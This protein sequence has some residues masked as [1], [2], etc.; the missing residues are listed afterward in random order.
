MPRL[1]LGRPL[2]L[3]RRASRPPRFSRYRGNL[4]VDVVIIGGGVT[5]A[6]A[7]YAFAD[8]GLAVALLEAGRI[9][10]GSTAASTALLMQEPDEDFRELVRRYGRRAARRMWQAIGSAT[11]DLVT[12]I[13][14]LRISCELRQ[15]SSIYYTHTDEVGDLREEFEARRAAGLK[16]R[17]L[18]ARA[19]KRR[20]GIAAA[21]AILTPG[22]AQ[23]DPYKACLG[24]AQRALARGARIFEYSAARRVKV[25]RG[26][27]AVTTKAGSLRAKCVVIATG[28]ATAEFKPLAG[29]FRMMNTYVIATPPLSRTIRRRL[30]PP[31]LML[32][33]TARPYHY[34]RWT[35]DGRLLFGGADTPHRPSRSRKKALDNGAAELRR[36]L[37]RLYPVLASHEADYVW[38]GLFAQTP[39]GLPYIGSHHR[40]PRHLFALG[41]GGNGMSVAYLA[42]RMLLRQYQG[43][44]TIDDGLFAFGRSRRRPAQARV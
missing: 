1:R 2:W 24:L 28:Y 44:S 22:N 8:A 10:R 32:W 18:S 23:L 13:K 33:D 11:T 26:G 25:L 39:D 3:D 27:V 40:Y 38:E 31:D 29:R 36:D 20:T 4:S 42:A 34:L 41:Y 12:L 17:W 37:R 15:G 6:I 19:V 43:E 5:G 30:A 21:G 9:G 14:R 7:A 16:G 35:T